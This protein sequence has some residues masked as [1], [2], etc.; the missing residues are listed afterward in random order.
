MEKLVAWLTLTPLMAPTL[1]W[2]RMPGL[3]A[4]FGFES[5]RPESEDGPRLANPQSLARVSCQEK[6]V[7]QMAT[8]LTARSSLC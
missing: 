8:R 6:S 3:Y 7:V 1:R 5:V 2:W 4:K